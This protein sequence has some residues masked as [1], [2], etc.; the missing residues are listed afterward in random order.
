VIDRTLAAI[1][2]TQLRIVNATLAVWT[3]SLGITNSGVRENTRVAVIRNGNIGDHIAALAT[4][5]YVRRLAPEGY[6]VLITSP[7]GKPFG[8]EL[9][10]LQGAFNE[11]VELPQVDGMARRGVFRDALRERRIDTVVYLSSDKARVSQVALDALA[12]RLA[13]VRNAGPFTTAKTRWFR[14]AQA[15]TRIANRECERLLLCVTPEDQAVAPDMAG[16]AP[17]EELGFT[18]PVIAVCPGAGIDLNRW[19]EER[20]ANLAAR[21]ADAGWSVAVLGGPNETA[22]AARLVAGLPP[23]RAKSFAGTGDLIAA[24]RVLRGC[25]CAVTNDT[26][27]A[28][29]AGLV[30]IPVVTVFSARDY[31]GSWLAGG[32]ALGV[33]HTVSCEVCYRR[34]CAHMT[35]IRSITVDDV[36]NAI[37]RV[38]DGETGMIIHQRAS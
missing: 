14:R 18:G 26:A 36:M 1:A 20:Y 25:T 21:L 23:G 32:R 35:C 31:P 19:P 22:A 7:G 38:L 6:V 3:R 29:L 11:I 10:E 37:R 5:A 2:D 28:H 17:V 8:R 4:Y 34:T 24:A 12:I 9:I 30:G 33:R 27:L 16:D 15:R 13:K